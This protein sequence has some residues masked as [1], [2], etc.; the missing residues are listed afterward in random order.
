MNPYNIIKWQDEVKDQNDN[1]LQEGTLHDEVNMNRMEEGIYESNL[2][3]SM[4]VQRDLQQKRVLAELEGEIGEVSLLNTDAFPFNNSIKTVAMDKPRDTTDYRIHTEVV[5]ADG[6]VGDIL[7]TDKQLNGFKI[8]FT[9][10][11]TNVTIKYY[12]QGGMYQ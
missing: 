4:L 11:A 6:N 3:A 7:I 10:S 1:I 2:M 9:G 5:S 8:A 12:I